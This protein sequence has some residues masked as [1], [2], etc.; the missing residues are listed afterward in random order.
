MASPKIDPT[1]KTT[2][3]DGDGPAYAETVMIHP[4]TVK[5][6]FRNWK[7]AAMVVLLAVYHIAPFLR[8]DR[9]PD[10]PSQAILADMAGR[11]GYFF[12][13]EIW[14]QEVYYITGLL[15]MAAIA[16]FFM[17]SLAGR[18]WCGFFCFQTV[19]TDLFMF[20]ERLVVGDRAKRMALDRAKWSGDKLVKKTIINAVWLV[21]AASCG[22]GFTLYFGDAPTMLRD[23]F[24]GRESTAVYG[25]IAVVGGGCFLLAGYAREQVCLYMC[26]YSRFQSAMFDEHSLII[27]YEEWRGEPRKPI[28]KGESFE[29]RGHCIDCRM[30]VAAC[31]TGI[32][33]R[34]GIQMA[35]IGCALCIDACDTM[36]DKYKLPRGLVTWDSSANLEARAKGDKTR[37]RLIRPRTIVYMAILSAVGALMIF[38]LSSRKTFDINVLHE[39]APLFVQLSNGSIRNGYTVKI[40]NMVRENRE[41][42]LSLSGIDGA[43]LDVVG[44][45]ASGGK[46]TLKVDP[47][48]VG[49]YN[50]FVTIPA[51]KLQAKRTPLYFILRETA[52]GGSNRLESLFASPER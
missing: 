9:G 17:S 35:C 33:I 18:I 15:F 24:A 30:C 16:L 52:K 28:R 2:A 8:W 38:G 19:Y 20:V 12:F 51:D 46:A 13:L 47:D 27:T 11:R 5:G 37:I 29:G 42:E 44:G 6:V 14:P 4:R 43:S 34:D 3:G 45:A 32:D 41:F 48:A 49:T 50:I 7:W 39:R 10:A 21:I 25:A 31:P 36:M 22:I 40:L 26:P 23:I 1:L